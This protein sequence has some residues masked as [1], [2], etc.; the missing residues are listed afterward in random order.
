MAI[1]DIYGQGFQ[2]LDYGEQPDLKVLS[3]KLLRMAGQTV[4]RF[5]SASARSAAIAAPVAGMTAWLTDVGR[6]EVYD[7]SA[8]AP[9]APGLTTTPSGATAAAGFS[10]V[11][12]SGRR[13]SSGVTMVN[14]TVTRTGPSIG[15]DSAGNIADTSLA[16]LPASWR[17][18]EQVLQ[19]IDDGFG[20]GSVVID[21][22]GL[23][24]LRTWS[25][26]GAI[27]AGRNLRVT[28]LY[29]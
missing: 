16:T 2:G 29:I 8:W 28:A 5:A 22:A 27:V 9:P 14:I 7:G 10:V 18:P 19:T 25:G 12:F 3:E 26:G 6:L 11:S 20:T 13:T 24:S 23:I 17:P 4:M 15:A 21:T 1:N